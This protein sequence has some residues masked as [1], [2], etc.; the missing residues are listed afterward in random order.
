M[1]KAS[2]L[3]AKNS[4]HSK[5]P[6]RHTDEQARMSMEVDLSKQGQLLRNTS[7]RAG[8][9]GLSLVTLSNTQ[10]RIKGTSGQSQLPK[11]ETQKR[12]E[13]LQVI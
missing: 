1:C 8:K 13:T 7:D 12:D 3:K 9:A 4:Q 10:L 5:P 11:I 6:P 2:A